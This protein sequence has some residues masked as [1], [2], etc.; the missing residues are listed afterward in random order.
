ML[1]LLLLPVLSNMI[2]SNVICDLFLHDNCGLRRVF[3]HIYLMCAALACISCLFHY[4]LRRDGTASPALFLLYVLVSMAMLTGVMANFYAQIP[5][6]A[7]VTTRPY[8]V[9]NMMLAHNM[10]QQVFVGWQ[11]LFIG[12]CF[13]RLLLPRRAY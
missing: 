13:T 12:F 2:N 9:T 4:L 1:F 3:W 6:K 8:L 7:L 5:Y 10:A 11:V